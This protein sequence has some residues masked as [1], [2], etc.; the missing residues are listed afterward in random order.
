[1][2]EFSTHREKITTN[3]DLKVQNKLFKWFLALKENP[4]YFS[5]AKIGSKLTPVS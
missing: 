3:S 1:M 2:N 5:V 4:E